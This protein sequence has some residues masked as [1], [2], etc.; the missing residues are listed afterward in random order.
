MEPMVIFSACLVVYCGYISLVEE[1]RDL[2][3]AR[4]LVKRIASRK[5]R[6]R[7]LRR[8]PAFAAPRRGGGGGARWPRPLAG[9]V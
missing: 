7:S 4:L 9:S 6:N 1:L 2:R 5:K 8:G 3:A